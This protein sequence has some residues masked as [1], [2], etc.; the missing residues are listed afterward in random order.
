VG[1]ILAMQKEYRI[2]IIMVAVFSLLP[3]FYH[4]N[5]YVMHVLV[6]FLIWGVV[7]A[8]WDLILGYA[9]IVSL[10]QIAFFAVGGYAS[11]MLSM[12]TGVSPWVCIAVGGIVAGVI[13]LGIGLPCLR[14]RGVYV[15]VVT[16]GLHLVMPT[17]L[18]RGR[19]FGTGGWYGLSN[20]PPLRVSAPLGLVPI[21]YVA[22]GIFFLLLFF[23]DKIIHSSIGLAFVALR[24]AEQFAESLGV[25][26]YKYKLMVFSMSAFFTGVMGAFYAHYISKITPA[27]LNL[28]LFLLVLVMVVLGGKGRFPGAVIGAFVLTVLNEVLRAAEIYRVLV[29]GLIIVLTMIYMPNGLMGSFELVAHS[30]GRRLKRS[31]VL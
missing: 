5:R 19:D 31:P 26:Q 28:D 30:I 1:V 11:G 3:F 22:L 20:I 27:I 16:L 10:G 12:S 13:G 17:L 9:G 24:E 4:E 25:N 6:L 23:M 18:M 7:A 2:Y 21:Y 15:A 8:A 14:L 29:L